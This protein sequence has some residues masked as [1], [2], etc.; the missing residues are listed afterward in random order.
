MEIQHLTHVWLVSV[1]VHSA[2]AQLPLNVS[3]VYKTI[4]YTQDHVFQIAHPNISV[5]VVIEPAIN[6]ILPANNALIV[7]LQTVLNATQAASYYL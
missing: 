3:N 1:H 2:T 7:M 5:R 4:S 6:A